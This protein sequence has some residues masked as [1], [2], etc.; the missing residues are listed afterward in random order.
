ME[1]N[2][3][4]PPLK[5]SPK[6]NRPSYKDYKSMC[7]AYTSC[8]KRG[9]VFPYRQSLN[10]TSQHMCTF[11]QMHMPFSLQSDS[12]AACIALHRSIIKCTCMSVG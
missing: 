1:P 7:I 8:P 9:F 12:L 4:E 5:D 10:V 6:E 11:D 3:V 2:T